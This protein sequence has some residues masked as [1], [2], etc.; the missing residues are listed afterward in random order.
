M[1]KLFDSP[2]LLLI[3][4]LIAVLLWGAPKLPG[5]AK[6]MGE[7]MRIFRK[8]MKTMSDERDQD[9]KEKGKEEKT[10]EK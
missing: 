2:W 7:S 4:V 9:K 10:S 5:I 3:V 8:E 1:N 6:S